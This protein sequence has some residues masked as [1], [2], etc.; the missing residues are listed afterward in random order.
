MN[1][2]SISWLKLKFW[3]TE[4]REF[5]FFFVTRIAFVLFGVSAGLSSAERRNRWNLRP[6]YSP[7]R[8]LADVPSTT[9]FLVCIQPSAPSWRLAVFCFPAFLPFVC[10]S[11][12]SRPGHLSV[13]Q[14]NL[15]A[16]NVGF[17]FSELQGSPPLD[18]LR[19]MICRKW[20]GSEKEKKKKKKIGAARHELYTDRN[21]E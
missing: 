8:C 15:A 20:R 4:C 5:C 1:K 18:E 13:I 7:R 21:R 19:A 6:L 11:R 10:L 9:L 14:S 16:A 3:H 12:P 2:V 17:D